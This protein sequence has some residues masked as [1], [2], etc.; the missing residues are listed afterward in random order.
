LA[1]KRLHGRNPVED[2]RGEHFWMMSVKGSQREL[3]KAIHN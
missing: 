3:P 1:L 2:E